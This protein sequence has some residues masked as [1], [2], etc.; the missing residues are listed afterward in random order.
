MIHLEMNQAALVNTRF[1][2]SPLSTTVGALYL[3]RSDAPPVGGGWRHLIRETV[4]D[5]Q[6]W[7]LKALFSGSWDYVPDFLT[8]Q[9][10]APE[11]AWAEEAHTVAT[12]CSER[13]CWELQIMAQGITDEGLAGRPTPTILRRALERGERDFAGDIA[14]ELHQLWESAI[15]PRWP[16]LRARMEAD[17]A[18]RAR[19]AAH[20]GLSGMLAG[21]HPRVAWNDDRLS[22]VTRF[23]AQIPGSTSLV[24][25]P[26][27]FAADLHMVIDPAGGPT[28]RQP[29]LTYPVLHGPDTPASPAAHALLGV[30]RARL[31]SDLHAART[32]AELSERHFLAPST[33]SYHLGILHRTGLL[34]RTRTGHRILYQQ[35]PRAAD[36]L[37]DSPQAR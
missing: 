31:L 19:T 17:I 27:V 3:L 22:L 29:M 13:L 35:T 8:P 28:P 30:T 16:A 4:H 10:D 20:H 11:A 6:L 33:V 24:L 32:T 12:T 36:L 25:T 18:L 1:A 34:T 23:Q 21:L 26:S 2:I 14:T 9:P 7:L 37:A 15:A 5:R